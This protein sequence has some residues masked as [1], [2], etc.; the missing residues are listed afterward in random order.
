MQENNKMESIRAQ[1]LKK[2]QP[3]NTHW[4]QISQ[5]WGNPRIGN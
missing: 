5:A 1:Y 2:K 3:Q 4:Y